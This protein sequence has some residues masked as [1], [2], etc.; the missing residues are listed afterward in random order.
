MSDETE[1]SEAN[2]NPANPLPRLQRAALIAEII[3]AFAVVL[4]LVF[5]GIQLSRNTDELVASSHH[6]LQFILNDN[7]NWFKDPEFAA[8]VIRSEQG[9]SVLTDA[10]YLQ[11]AYW[12]GQR[13][14]L[15]E[16]VF[17]RRQDGLID[18]QMWYAWSNGCASI[19]ENAT[20]REVWQERRKWFAPD[21]AL[22][23]DEQLDALLLVETAASPPAETPGD[24][25][26]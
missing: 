9:R 12:N 21:F 8:L 20:S 24:G 2:G 3:A 6:Q 1:H 25:A 26:Q 7:D 5:V 15:C 18:D 14:S 11:L 23:F 10:E 4:S 19:A 13:L 22:W 16:N 17:Q